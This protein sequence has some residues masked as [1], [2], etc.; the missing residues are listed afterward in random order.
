MPTPNKKIIVVAVVAF[1]VAASVAKLIIFKKE[2]RYAGTIE[3]TKIDIPSRLSS[4]IAT[5]TSKEGDK[6]QS[7]QMLLTLSCEDY[8][9]NANLANDNYA[10]AEQLFK[11]GS[12]AKQD[13][14]SVK[15]KKDDADLRVS[16][17]SIKAP[18]TGTI[19]TKYHETGEMV[20]P[21]TK[22]FTVADIKDIYAYI[23]VPQPKIASLHLQDKVSGILPEL[24]GRIFEGTITWIADEA[25]FT[26]KNVQ[27]E[28]ERTRLVYAVK[29][30]FKNDDETLKPGMT[31][32]V[33]LLAE[34]K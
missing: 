27:T 2:F 3:A 34:R 8:T 17:C 18:I 23:Y 4:V 1:V 24:N 19:L 12:L 16:W 30:A 25:E 21:G 29:V 31:I 28:A 9:L 33:N 22:L 7:G 20:S 10:R 26:P 5:L 15:N 14:D 32:E 6:V 11:E 13:Y